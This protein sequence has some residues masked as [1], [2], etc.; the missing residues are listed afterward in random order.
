MP[1]T[2]IANLLSRNWAIMPRR[3]L[4]ILTHEGWIA[5]H[6]KA[7]AALRQDFATYRSWIR[8]YDTLS[9]SARAHMREDFAGW[10]TRP[11]ISI[12]MPVRGTSRHWLGASVASVQSQIYPD[13]ELCICEDASKDDRPRRTA[14]GMAGVDRRI[15]VATRDSRQNIS[16]TWNDAIASASGT[17]VALM[18]ANDVLPEHALYMMAKELNEHLEVDL[19]FSDEDTIDGDGHRSDPYFKPDWNPALMLSR[20]AFGALGVYRKSLVDKIGGLRAD[21]ACG[22][23]HDLALRCAQLATPGR[24]RHV[25]RILYHRR[26]PAALGGGGTSATSDAAAVAW[27]AERRAIEEQLAGDGIRGTV[28]PAPAPQTYQVAYALPS[29]PPSVSILIPTACAKQLIEPCLQSLLTRSSY[30]NF[31]VLLLVNERD[32]QVPDKAAFLAQF[33]KVPRVRV[34]AYPDQPFNYSRVNNWGAEQASG[35][36]LC[37]LNDDTAV[38]TPQWLEQLA[39]RAVLPHVAG[40]GPLLLYPN[41]TI[42]HAGVILGLSGVAGHACNGLSKGAHGYFDRACLEQD[43]SCLT[44]ACLV[45]RR[46]VFRDLGGFDEQLPIAFNDVDLCLR[47]RAAGWRLIWTPAVELYHHESESVGRHDSPERAKEFA[48]AVALMRSRWGPELD[49]DPCYNPNLS[50]QLGFRLA[51]PPRIAAIV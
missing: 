37:F 42:Q 9:E 36:L 10:K 24:I 13:W 22:H 17:F 6:E 15:R 34:L 25:P 16:A 27:E 32:R 18:N 50:L 2:A 51:F 45:M 31:E 35:D 1:D 48:S 44:A 47:V 49:A 30:G 46:T 5:L 19:A 41:G 20:D 12:I 8:K 40:A 14:A 29:P 39:A 4:R 3:I 43:V 26:D 28:R 7:I 23:W 38:I 21:L 11:R 33:A